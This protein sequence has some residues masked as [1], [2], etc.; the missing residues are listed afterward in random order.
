[1]WLHECSLTGE[2]GVWDSGWFFTGLSRE[3]GNIWSSLSSI[4]TRWHSVSWVVAQQ[5]RLK[6]Y[7]GTFYLGKSVKLLL[8]PNT[9]NAEVQLTLESSLSCRWLFVSEQ[10]WLYEI[11]LPNCRALL[12]SKKK[13]SNILFTSSNMWERWLSYNL[14]H[15]LE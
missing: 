12:C 1:M 13:K 7:S 2:K 14:V 3:Y 15:Q 9:A 10:D 4:S 6:R 8:S 11:T 5:Y